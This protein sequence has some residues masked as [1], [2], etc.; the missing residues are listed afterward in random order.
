MDSAG[1]V[2]VHVGDRFLVLLLFHRPIIFQLDF[3][4]VP[5]LIQLAEVVN[6]TFGVKIQ[7][8]LLFFQQR[9]LWLYYIYR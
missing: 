8:H 3:K 4:R 5:S 2:V 1:A 9:F 6:I 7:S